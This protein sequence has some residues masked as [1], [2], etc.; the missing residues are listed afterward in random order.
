[1]LRYA[2]IFLTMLFF[3]AGGIFPASAML[4]P[5]AADANTLL[6]EHSTRN[7]SSDGLGLLCEVNQAE[8]TKTYH[9]DQVGST[10]LRTDDSGTVIGKAEYSAY[11]IRFWQQG[12]MATPFL[13]NGQW[14]VTTENNGLLHMR[15]RYYSPY[16][17]RFLNADPIGFSGGSNWFVYAD[18]NP[19][20]MSDPFG[21]CAI[22]CCTGKPYDSSIYGRRPSTQLTSKVGHNLLDVAGLIPGLG[23]LADGA[24]GIWYASVGNALDSTLSFAGMIPFAGWGATGAKH[25]DEVV[26]LAKPTLSA[27]KE[28]MQEV[29]GEVGKLP[30]G[31]D[32]KFGSPQAGDPRKGYRLDPAHPNAPAGSPEAVPHINWW[33]YTKGKRGS[34]GRSGAVPIR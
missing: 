24:N 33:D 22:D 11:G 12:D 26:D 5:A 8:Q 19:I 20:S 28:A 16:L 9:Y 29:Y 31:P 27:H 4:N 6:T 15:A 3:L 30:R 2:A 1:L 13:Y 21:L 7:T 18:G 32:G 25:A 14:G 10:I 17:M 23:E 34:G